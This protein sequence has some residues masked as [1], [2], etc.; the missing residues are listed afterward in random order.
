MLTMMACLTQSAVCGHLDGTLY[1]SVSV[2]KFL[3]TFQMKVAQNKVTCNK[4]IVY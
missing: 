1:G 3:N 4:I 2:A